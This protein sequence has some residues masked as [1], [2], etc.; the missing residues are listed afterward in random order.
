[1]RGVPLGT[2]EA[3]TWLRAMTDFADWWRSLQAGPFPR[4]VP[5]AAMQFFRSRMVLKSI[6][7]HRDEEA[8]RLERRACHGGRSS[9][10]FAGVVIDPTGRTLLPDER[11]IGSCTATV[12]GPVYRLDVRSMY[13]SLLRDR[14]YPV[15]LVKHSERY[16]VDDIQ[17]LSKRY[18]VIAD[19]QLNDITGEYPN[20][21]GESVGYPVGVFRSVLCGPELST[22]LASGSVRIVYAAAVYEMGR[23]F[24]TAAGELCEMRELYRRRGQKHYELLSKLLGNSLAGKLAQRPRGW[25]EVPGVGHHPEWDVWI[26]YNADTREAIHRRSIAGR[27][28]EYRDIG[29][30]QGCLTACFA[31]LTS[32]GRSL[33]R[34]YRE[35]CPPRSVYAQDTDGIWVSPAGLA[36]LH[37]SYVPLADASPGHLALAE[38]IESMYWLSPK[39]Y[40]TPKGWTLA[41][42]HSPGLPRKGMVLDTYDVNPVR[43]GCTAPPTSV[44]H[45]VI[46]KRLPD[47]P[48]AHLVGADGWIRPIELPEMVDREPVYGPPLPPD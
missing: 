41:G 30:G 26:D 12:D 42:Y 15:R 27:V 21:Q 6:V 7:V 2:G 28:Y 9:L 17:S 16:T 40:C 38:R 25:K 35:L 10:W 29:V 37:G 43:A 19:V 46:T 8:Y 45:F 1:M 13:P 3:T 4:T 5:S 32:Y 20:R 22:A 33:M 31:F 47:P 18:G 24:A 39:H 11:P 36:A 14:E 44:D 48:P 34:G 23:P